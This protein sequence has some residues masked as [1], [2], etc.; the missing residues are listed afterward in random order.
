MWRRSASN[1]AATHRG[2]VVSHRQVLV[3]FLE[4]QEKIVSFLQDLNHRL[5]KKTDRSTWHIWQTLLVSTM[6]LTSKCRDLNQ[7]SC[8]AKTPWTNLCP[9]WNIEWKK[10]QKM[11]CDISHCCW[12]SLAAF[13]VRLYAPSYPTWNC[14]GRR[15]R[16]VLLIWGVFVKRIAGD[17]S[18]HCIMHALLRTWSISAVKM[19]FVIF[20]QIQSQRTSSKSFGLSKETLLLQ[21]WR[22]VQLWGLSFHSTLHIHLKLPSAPLYRLKQKHRLNVHQDFRLAVTSI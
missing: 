5:Y 1:T 13:Y 11:T 18:L 12:N 4:L 19:S 7:R 16:P 15:L 14:S 8:S 17:E 6:K 3:R 20:K 10:C 22:N 21:G 9:K 2:E